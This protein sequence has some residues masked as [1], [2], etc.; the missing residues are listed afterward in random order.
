MEFFITK[1][2]LEELSNMTDFDKLNA[3]KVPDVFKYKNKC[4]VC[5]GSIS[6]LGKGL[7][8]VSCHELI[9]L[10]KYEGDVKPEY[11]GKH[12]SLVMEGKR[13]RGYHARLLKSGSQKFVMIDPMIDFKPLKEPEQLTFFNH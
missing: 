13:Q 5:V 9:P 1:Q 4:Y 12:Y 6:S 11:S 10:E 7:I 8:S 2:R 3:S